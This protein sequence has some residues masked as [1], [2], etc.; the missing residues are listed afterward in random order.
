MKILLKNFLKGC[1]VLLPTGGTLYVVWSVFRRIDGWMPGPVPGVGILLAFLLTAAV[2]ALA[3]NVL[4]RKLF[5]AT[6]ALLT[7]LPLVKLLYTTLRDF[8]GALVGERRSF[9]RPVLVS[10]DGDPLGPKLLGFMTCEDLARFELLDHVAVYCPQAINFA[11]NLLILPRV[12]VRPLAVDQ[13]EFM[14][15]VVSGGVVR[16]APRAASIPPS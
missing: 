9:D 8:M 5:A 7:R 10:L 13:A 12:R 16:G 1:L 4:G 3:S 2:G 14:A 6:E 11:G 15:F